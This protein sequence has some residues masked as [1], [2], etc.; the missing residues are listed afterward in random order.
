MSNE[1]NCPDW[2]LLTFLAGLLIVMVSPIYFLGKSS[3]IVV[4]ENKLVNVFKISWFDI[5][6]LTFLVI[7]GCSI[8]FFSMEHE[9][10]GDASK[11]AKIIKFFKSKGKRIIP[12][13]LF[14]WLNS[15]ASF[16][17]IASMVQISR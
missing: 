15:V 14:F 7:L 2:W 1:K 13:L 3:D 11:A 5:S 8:A 6:L 10:Y 16:T 17:S 4:H 9:T 12:Y